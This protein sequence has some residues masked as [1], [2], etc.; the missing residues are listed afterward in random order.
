MWMKA[1]VWPPVPC[2]VRVADRRL[3]E[4]AV[5]HG[6]VVAVIVEAVDQLLVPPCLLRVGAPDDAL[7]EVGDP[8]SVVLRV[9]LEQQ[10]IQA[11]CH[12]VD[13]ARIGRIENFLADGA[14][15]DRLDAD[16]QVAFR[17]SGADR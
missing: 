11:L 15:V 6:A 2:T 17:N 16:R 14:A 12:V 1:R 5:E 7:V 3:D 8:Q 9:E 4:E 10:L 13:G